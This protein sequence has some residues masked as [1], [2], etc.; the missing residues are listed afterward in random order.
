MTNLETHLAPKFLSH[1]ALHFI[2]EEHTVYV[3]TQGKQGKEAD[4]SLY[5]IED[6][7]FSNLNLAGVHFYASVFIRCQFVNT[8]L[9]YTEFDAAKAPC[10]NFQGAMLAKASFYEADLSDACFDGAKLTSASFLKSDLMRATFR[11]AE[12]DSTSFTDSN[13]TDAVFDPTVPQS[14]LQ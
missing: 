5:I 11:F 1:E 13:L 3:A 8:D 6:Y 2:L 14:V 10:G 12:I 9:Y 7:D 4:L